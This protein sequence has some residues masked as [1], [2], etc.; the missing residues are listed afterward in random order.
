MMRSQLLGTESTACDNYTFVMH[1]RACMK[2]CFIWQLDLAQISK[3]TK[4]APAADTE[5]K[6]KK[7]MKGP[8]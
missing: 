8:M 4:I 7:Q 3:A 2:V 6:Q 1:A 5:M